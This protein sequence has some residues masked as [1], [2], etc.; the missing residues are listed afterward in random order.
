M[1]ISG[2][3]LRELTEEKLKKNFV[4][5]I[6]VSWFIFVYSWFGEEYF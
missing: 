3:S 1:E 5:E 6:R 2:V 4:D